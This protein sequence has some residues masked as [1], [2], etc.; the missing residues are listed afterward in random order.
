[1]VPAANFSGLAIQWA[2][3]HARSALVASGSPADFTKAMVDTEC[4]LRGPGL[5]GTDEIYVNLNTVS[6]ETADIFNIA[7]RGATGY[8]PGV[9]N[10]AQPGAWLSRDSRD[11]TAMLL[12]DQP[13]K[14]WF[15]A[16]GRRFIVIARV[17]S[18]YESMYAGLGHPYAL[19]SEF[20]YMLICGGSSSNDSIRYS[21]VTTA[22]SSFWHPA[23][24][25]NSNLRLASLRMRDTA[26]VWQG[27]CNFYGS[28]DGYL[29]PTNSGS[30]RDD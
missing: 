21:A 26:G 22:H 10:Y 30:R 27:F 23:K 3:T 29:Y 25:S 11:Q 20:P 9:L 8:L 2:L 5:S 24:D 15:I 14:Y 6:S 16:N 28:F 19:P 18:V 4:A 13:I 17:T 7:L 1:I 12:W